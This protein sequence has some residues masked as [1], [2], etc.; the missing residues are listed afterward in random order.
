MALTKFQLFEKLKPIY[1]YSIIILKRCAGK[2][3]LK[4]IY[5]K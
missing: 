2:A 1:S 5:S 3:M 4:Y